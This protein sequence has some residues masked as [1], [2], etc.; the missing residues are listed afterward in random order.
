MAKKFTERE[1]SL[2]A[3]MLLADDGTHLFQMRD[4]PGLGADAERIKAMIVAAPE[5]LRALRE[6]ADLLSARFQNLSSGQFE[7][8]ELGA[9]AHQ[10]DAATAKA[11]GRP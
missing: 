5:M 2:K 1:W 4:Q 8:E 9:L 3:D 11:E 6:A 10:I 7:D